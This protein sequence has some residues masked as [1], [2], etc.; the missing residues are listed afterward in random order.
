MITHVV[1]VSVLDKYGKNPGSLHKKLIEVLSLSLL[2]TTTRA[3]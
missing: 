2:P 1:W 3:P